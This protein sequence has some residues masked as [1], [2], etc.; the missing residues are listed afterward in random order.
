MDESTFELSIKPADVN[1]S[2]FGKSDNFWRLKW[3]KNSSVVTYWIGLPGTS[4]LPAGLT[5]FNSK[6][7]SNFPMIFITKPFEY[8]ISLK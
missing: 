5:Q 4:F 2:T 8:S 3:L 6:N 1:S 7:I